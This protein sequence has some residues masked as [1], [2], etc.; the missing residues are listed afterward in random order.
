MP[1][2]V[3]DSITH[4]LWETNLTSSRLLLGMA[5]MLWAI[6]LLWPGDT[7]GRPTYNGMSTVMSEEA[8]ALVF[9]L[10]SVTQF[11]IVIRRDFHCWPARYF[12]AWNMVLWCFV[13]ISMLLSVYPPPA[14]IS[15]E[16]CLAIASV[17][18]WLRPFLL[19]RGIERARQQIR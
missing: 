15:A 3:I 17:W 10:S 2:K 9:A 12:A 16:I 1:E 18:I 14:A 4:A 7:F 6:L 11:T 19:L 5:E 8:W 13:V